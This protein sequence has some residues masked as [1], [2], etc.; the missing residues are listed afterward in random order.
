MG[1]G[2]SP[3]IIHKLCLLILVSAFKREVD[4]IPQETKQNIGWI[5][6]RNRGRKKKWEKRGAGF[7]FADSMSSCPSICKRGRDPASS[8][9]L[10]LLPPRF[11]SYQ[12]TSHE[13]RSRG[14]QVFHSSQHSFAVPKAQ[15]FLYFRLN[16]KYRTTFQH[17][18]YDIYYYY[19]THLQSFILYN[20][21]AETLS[22]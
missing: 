13:I 5:L 9:P 14:A 15:S 16:C 12:S 19:Q 11:P 2:T 6:R 1:F 4:H 20:Y 7:F 3:V 10:P 17:T 8:S 22:E 18:L 21:S